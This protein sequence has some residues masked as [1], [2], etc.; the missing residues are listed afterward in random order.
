MG[1]HG[2]GDRGWRGDPDPGARRR[3]RP[4]NAPVAAN[5][6]A[7]PAPPGEDDATWSARTRAALQAHDA[8]LARRFDQGEEVDRLVALRARAVDQALKEAWARCIPT[9]APLAL[10]AVGG[11]GRGELFPHSD[12]D[13]LVLADADSQLDQHDGL[14]CF[15]AMLWDAGLAASH[16]VRSPDQCTDAAA[17]Q[18]V[19]TALIEWRA[20]V[21][22][23][24]AQAALAAAISPQR[25]WPPR[26]FFVAKREELRARHARFGDT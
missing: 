20:L 10:F 3:Q 14:A 25:V 23:E 9:E 24:A 6:A 17:D 16:A 8:K 13:L 18:T 21:A 2:R 4:V 5:D 12:I 26:D 7:A 1:A 11:Y 19:L 15:F 22:D